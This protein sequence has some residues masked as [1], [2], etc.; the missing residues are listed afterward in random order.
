M[1]AMLNFEY[2]L[3]HRDMEKTKEPPVNAFRAAKGDIQEFHTDRGG[4]EYRSQWALDQLVD[5]SIIEDFHRS[6]GYRYI[7]LRDCANAAVSG[8][9]GAGYGLNGEMKI[10]SYT[11][12]ARL[13]R[14]IPQKIMKRAH[15]VCIKDT[16]NE[17]EIAALYM[18]APDIQHALELIDETTQKILEAL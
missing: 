18:F 9:R 8:A 16:F 10:D 14:E 17:N 2:K 7:A 11:L 4:H 15:M 6:I 5:R 13:L 12:H 1:E 3:G